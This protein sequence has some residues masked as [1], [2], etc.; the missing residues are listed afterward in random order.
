MW[1]KVDDFFISVGSGSPS[2]LLITFFRSA[3]RVLTSVS[4]IQDDVVTL[5]TEE[6]GSTTLA[7]EEVALMTFAITWCKM[8]TVGRTRSFGRLAKKDGRTGCNLWAA[9]SLLFF[10]RVSW[11][12]LLLPGLCCFQ[13]FS[14]PPIPTLISLSHTGHHIWP[15]LMIRLSLVSVL[16]M[17]L[18]SSWILWGL[19]SSHNTPLF[20][21]DDLQHYQPPQNLSHV[22]Y[23]C[24]RVLGTM[25][26]FFLVHIGKDV[27]ITRW[28]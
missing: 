5:A 14:S 20:V 10:C 22:P 2:R 9:F 21:I 26:E 6:V 11:H 23:C 17:P 4:G 8:G 12:A 18:A 25:G 27:R 13:K 1:E 16:A 19:V 7:A 28:H 15:L 24:G 3:S